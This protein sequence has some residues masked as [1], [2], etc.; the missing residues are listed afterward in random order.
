VTEDLEAAYARLLD[1]LAQEGADLNAVLTGLS[2][3]QW[4]LP[5][6]ADR[7][8]IAHQV[9]HLELTENL[10]HLAFTDAAAFHRALPSAPPEPPITAAD[11]TDPDLGPR[12]RTRWYDA[13]R[14][15]LAAFRAGHPRDRMPWVGPPLSLRTAATSRIMEIWAHGEDILTAIGAHREP[16]HRLRHIAHLAVAARDFSF[17]NRGLAPPEEA[18]RVVIHGPDGQEWSWGPPD[19]VQQVTGEA[20]DFA[21]LATRRIHPDDASVT[22]TGADARRW[23]GIIQAFAGDPGPQRQATGQA[24]ATRP[25]SA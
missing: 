17:H 22:A 19:A 9:G 14:R 18:F 11:L 21:L 1:D 16:T 13:H 12:L 25:P 10:M 5:T 2:A 7:W 3:E 6:P 23:L 20:Y 8:T 24:R 15:L 4:V